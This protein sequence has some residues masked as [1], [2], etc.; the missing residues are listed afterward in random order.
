[1]KIKRSSTLTGK[2]HI[3]EIDVTHEQL[4]DYYYRVKLLQQAFPNI[5]APLREFIK[6]GITPQEWKETFG[7]PRNINDIAVTEYPPDTVSD[8]P[9]VPDN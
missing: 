1:M 7:D 5:P 2:T 3:L 6:T 9:I 4:I 8:E